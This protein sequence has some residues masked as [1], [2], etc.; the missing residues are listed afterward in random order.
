MRQIDPVV[1]DAN[2]VGIQNPGT[3]DVVGHILADADLPVRQ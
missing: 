1:D 2:L 3:A